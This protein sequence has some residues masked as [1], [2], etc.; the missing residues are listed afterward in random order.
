MSYLQLPEGKIVFGIFWYIDI[1]LCDI[2]LIVNI[3]LV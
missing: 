2:I 1:H 3:Q